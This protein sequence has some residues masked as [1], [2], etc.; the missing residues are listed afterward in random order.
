MSPLTRRELLVGAAAAGAVGAVG[1]AGC[2][3]DSKHAGGGSPAATTTAT[4]LEGGLADPSKA[5]FDTVVVLMMENRSFDHLLGWLPGADG[6]Q[7]GQ[8]FIDVTG[9]KHA[10]WNIGADA[11]GCNYADPKHDWHAAARQF[12]NGKADGFLRTQPVGDQFPISYY[13]QQD[14]PVLSALATNYTAFD[15]YYCSLLAATWPNRFYQHCATTDIDDTGLYPGPLGAKGMPPAN[16]KRPSNLQLAIWDRIKDAGLKGGYYYHDEPMTGLFASKRYDDI[17]YPYAQFL[18]DAKAGTLPNVTFVDP[19]YGTVSEYLGTSNDMHPHGSVVVGDAFV[20]EVYDALR[21]SPQWDRMVFVINFDEH[22]GF[23]DHVA[24]PTVP[25]DTD[26]GPAAEHP[27]YKRLGFRVPAIAISPFA[28]KKVETA[29]PYEHCSVLRMIEWRWGL[30]PMTLRDKHAKNLADA[31][32]FSQRRAAITLPAYP[33]PTPV[34]C[35]HPTLA[36][37]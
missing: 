8:T 5:P 29:G 28:P 25:D 20:A 15:H 11:Q 10:S 4:T 1:V 14:L 21:K 36:K 13:G 26:N 7:A 9:A 31:L 16:A 32:D 33:D 12:N 37:A 17:S 3:S 34:A 6:R 24:P 22:G 27:D 18:T 19:D 2:S 35:P 23:S 30:E